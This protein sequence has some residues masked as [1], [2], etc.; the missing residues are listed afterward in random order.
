MRG[1]ETLRAYLELGKVALTL[2]VVATTAVGFILGRPKGGVGI[3]VGIAAL[4]GTFLTAAGAVA[5]NQAR[6][7]KRDA[8]M[9]RTERRPIPTGR[10]PI[11]RAVVFGA[12]SV[13]GGVALLA[14]RVNLLTAALGLAN[15][16]IYVWIYTPLKSR[17]SICTLVGAVCGAI[18]PMMGWTAAAGRLEFGAWIL[19]AMLFLWQIPHFLALA[20][21]YR[22]DYEKGGFQILPVVDRS[23]DMTSRLA[24]LYSL[25]TVPLAL[26]SVRA[27]MGGWI[28][29]ATAIFLAAGLA[30][31][32]IRLMR[33]R[34]EA[35]A[36]ALFFA[37]LIYLP[38]LLGL[39][40][41]DRGPGVV[42]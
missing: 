42:P 17:T 24:V 15:F 1:S 34:T 26:V 30:V 14:F 28:F 19:G 31:L 12:C 7:W 22:A 32:G 23:G 39:L 33:S 13:A 36:R 25:A 10:I 21:L 2:L 40:V 3:E 11:R 5:M 9:R 6:E 27:G 18:P 16:A 41:A 37:S 8:M 35:R 38:V 29:L 4:A 20:W